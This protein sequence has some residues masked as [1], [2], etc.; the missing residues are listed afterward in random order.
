M[1]SRSTLLGVTSDSLREDKE[2][3]NALFAVKVERTM[4]SIGEMNRFLMAE[5]IKKSLV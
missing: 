3:V 4:G 5:I 1:V 2:D